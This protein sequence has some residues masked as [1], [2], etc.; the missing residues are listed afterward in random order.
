[1]KTQ[2]SFFILAV[3][4]CYW[5]NFNF[6]VAQEIKNLP[7]DSLNVISDNAEMEYTAER[8]EITEHTSVNYK[9]KV[10][11]FE[12]DTFDLGLLE[13]SKISYVGHFHCKCNSNKDI[14]IIKTTISN[15]Q[16]RVTASPI[17]SAGT[18]GTILCIID[19]QSLSLGK[20]TDKITILT[21]SETSPEICFHITYEIVPKREK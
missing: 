1:M 18:R 5:C 6:A 13:R 8:A 14:H 11:I 16:S 10:L 21:D 17:I 7:S 9:D 3:V 15:G 2:H 4:A 20:H 19:K 12:K